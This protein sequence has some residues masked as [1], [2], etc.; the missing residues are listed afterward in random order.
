MTDDDDLTRLR[1][2]ERLEVAE[3]LDIPDTW[4][5]V[6]VTAVLVRIQGPVRRVGE[7]SSAKA[8][9]IRRSRRGSATPQ[10][11][12]NCTRPVCDA[13]KRSATAASNTPPRM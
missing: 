5:K 3:L 7:S 13:S 4:L 1:H 11:E 12:R 8:A 2:Y 9:R 6:W 10:Q